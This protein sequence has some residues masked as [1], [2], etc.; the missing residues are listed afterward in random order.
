MGNRDIDQSAIFVAISTLSPTCRFMAASRA[1]CGRTISGAN[2]VF[3]DA[4]T[5]GTDATSSSVVKMRY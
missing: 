3:C 2:D 4:A 1:N 5:D